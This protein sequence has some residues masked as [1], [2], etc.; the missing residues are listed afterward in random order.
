MPTFSDLTVH[1]PSVHTHPPPQPSTPTPQHHRSF[2]FLRM[3]KT[4]LSLCPRCNHSGR[5]STLLPQRHNRLPHRTASY[6][7][8]PSHSLPICQ[9][10]TNFCGALACVPLYTRSRGTVRASLSTL[11]N[12]DRNAAIARSSPTMPISPRSPRFSA[13]S[14]VF[15]FL[16]VA[17]RRCSAPPS[18][19]FPTVPHL[20]QPTAQP[21]PCSWMTNIGKPSNTIT[22]CRPRLR[23][24]SGTHIS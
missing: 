16:L 2:T 1:A 3:R 21:L 15:L 11:P 17:A 9:Q 6:G 18:S 24:R 12:S 8:P 13:H 19:S 20:R 14:A 23:P 22:V 4:D 10:L 5:K 7:A